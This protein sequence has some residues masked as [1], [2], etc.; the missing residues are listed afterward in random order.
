MNY[1]RKKVECEGKEDQAILA[2]LRS[3]TAM[4]FDCIFDQ[5]YNTLYN[6][7]HHFVKSE[8]ETQDLITETFIRFWNERH[9]FNAPSLNH[10]KR[11]LLKIARN[12]CIN[13]RYRKMREMKFRKEFVYLRAP[14]A[15]EFR[16]H[17]LESRPEIQREIWVIVQQVLRGL[18][19]QCFEVIDLYYIKGLS[20]KEIAE[21]LNVEVGTIKARKSYAISLIKKR[22]GG[23]PGCT[24][25]YFD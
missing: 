9:R 10:V 18:P 21:S 14:D 5:N 25:L 19:R 4:A 1:R 13:E 16:Q 3:G 22:I 17:T 15:D 20:L 24:D 7:I 2:E 6:Y 23:I 11:Y 8:A 12:L